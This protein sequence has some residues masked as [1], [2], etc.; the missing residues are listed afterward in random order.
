[1]AH[2]HHHHHRKWSALDPNTDHPCSPS[3]SA[4]AQEAVETVKS[5]Q[6]NDEHIFVKDSCDIT[7]TT[8]DTQAAVN[9]QVAIQLAI[10]LILN[11]SIADGHQADSV[12]Q[13]LLQRIRTRQDIHQKTHIENSRGVTVTT[14]ST[15]VSLNIQV[16]LQ[17]LLALI[18]KLEIL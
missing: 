3:G 15:E 17:V 7:I 16:L 5:E 2:H 13:E 10:A 6:L 11:I 12:A 4:V 1:M 18:A 8:T 9:L 14:T